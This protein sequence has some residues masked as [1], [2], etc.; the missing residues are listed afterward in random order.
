M[1]VSARSNLMPTHRRSRR[2]QLA[3][4]SL[5]ASLST[6][7]KP[8]SGRPGWWVVA[9]WLLL[10]AVIAGVLAMHILSAADSGGS[11]RSMAMPSASATPP[12]A[13]ASM[14]MDMP[15]VK[16]PV[17]AMHPINGTQLGAVAGVD[18]S[19]M[20]CC[21]LFLV[22]AVGLVL[23][24]RSYRARTAATAGGTRGRAAPSTLQRGPPGPG[25]PRIA[26]SILRV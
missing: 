12:A 10:G 1:S 16:S 8:V 26:L 21:V 17:Q 20:S 6:R 9:R 15:A 11:H 25:Y 3:A 19:P 5:T 24:V 14:V 22:S 13:S 4:G 18:M 2:S 23:L 7:R